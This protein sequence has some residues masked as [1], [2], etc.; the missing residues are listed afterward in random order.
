[1]P[2][3]IL[4]IMFLLKHTA[5]YP[6]DIVMFYVKFKLKVVVFGDAVPSMYVWLFA[7]RTVYHVE[8]SP[9]C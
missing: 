7:P 5:L 4:T 3:A 9:I 8:L 1:M 6:I 2:S